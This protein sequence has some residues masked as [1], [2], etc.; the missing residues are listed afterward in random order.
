MFPALIRPLGW[1]SATDPPEFVFGPVVRREISSERWEGV[2]GSLGCAGDFGVE[3]ETCDSAGMENPTIVDVGRAFLLD[4]DPEEE[5][6]NEAHDF[7]TG[8]T[9]GVGAGVVSETVSVTVVVS[10]AEVISVSFCSEVRGSM[11]VF[12]ETGEAECVWVKVSVS[13][14]TSVSSAGVGSIM[15]GGGVTGGVGTSMALLIMSGGGRAKGEIMMPGAFAGSVGRLDQMAQVSRPKFGLDGVG[16][17]TCSCCRSPVELAW[18]VSTAVGGWLEEAAS[19]VWLEA[20][21]P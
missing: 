14:G 8:G 16:A 6:S 2:N 12:E 11:E 20:S 9:A 19:A 17:D 15:T 1:I 5:E 7:L 4:A 18:A 13:V 21:I 10:G 3:L